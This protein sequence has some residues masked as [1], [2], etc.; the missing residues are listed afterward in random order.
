[1]TRKTEQLKVLTR[2]RLLGETQRRHEMAEILRRQHEANGA[3]EAIEKRIDALGEVQSRVHAAETDFD[4]G[5]YQQL[6]A[7]GERLD[8][9]QREQRL[10]TEGIAQLHRA[11][12]RELSNAWSHRKAAEHRQEREARIERRDSGNRRLLDQLEYWLSGQKDK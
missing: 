4:V 6:L 5:R 3:L 10:E 7:V 11:K 9:E 12:T 8:D 2:F 1:M